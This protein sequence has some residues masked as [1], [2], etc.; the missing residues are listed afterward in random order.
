MDIEDSN[1]KEN[2]VVNE[3]DECL[4]DE[5]PVNVALEPVLT[6]NASGLELQPGRYLSRHQSNCPADSQ[7]FDKYTSLTRKSLEVMS[8]VADED[9]ESLVHNTGIESGIPS[10]PLTSESFGVCS[11]QSSNSDEGSFC[12]TSVTNQAC[13]VLIDEPIPTFLEERILSF[14]AISSDSGTLSS[15]FFDPFPFANTIADIIDPQ[16]SDETE[17]SESTTHDSLSTG[18]MIDKYEI[19]TDWEYD[20]NE[21]KNGWICGNTRNGSLSA[22][23]DTEQMKALEGTIERLVT[24]IRFLFNDS[25]GRCYASASTG[26]NDEYNYDD[27]DD[28]ND[29]L[30]VPLDREP[31]CNSDAISMLKDEI[32]TVELSLEDST[33]NSLDISLESLSSSS[34]ESHLYPP[35]GD[36]YLKEEEDEDSL[37][38]EPNVVAHT[39]DSKR[40]WDTSFSFNRSLKGDISNHMG[41]RD[42][43]S[44]RSYNDQQSFR[45]CNI[46]NDNL[47]LSFSSVKRFEHLPCK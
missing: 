1:V 30:L 41:A 47:F 28:T 45:Q 29:W 32:A 33:Q 42:A 20:K 17:C 40:D 11:L 31:L 6:E 39:M 8:S 2:C 23:Q 18:T 46:Q 26:G 22:L 15:T 44:K 34:D 7:I 25:E 12:N 3:A 27:M 43:T 21:T 5:M 38:D 24:V 4:I 37:H 35:Y 19:G 10:S 36:K 9:I 16:G 13:E 14:L